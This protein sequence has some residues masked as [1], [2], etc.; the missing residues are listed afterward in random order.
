MLWQIKIK[1]LFFGF[2]KKK[3]SLENSLSYHPDRIKITVN[4]KKPDELIT[5]KKLK[6]PNLIKLDIEGGELKFLQGSKKLLKH[7]A[8]EHLFIEVHFTKLNKLYGK[9]SV[10]KII[11]VF[12]SY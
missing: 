6:I 12:Y 10:K 1:K 5:K 11:K 9:N 7:K 2:Q 8:L 4:Q 3:N